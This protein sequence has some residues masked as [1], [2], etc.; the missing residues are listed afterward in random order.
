MSINVFKMTCASTGKSY[1]GMTSKDMMTEATNIFHLAERGGY[2][3]IAD[4]MVYDICLYGRDDFKVELIEACESAGEAKS[5]RADH[6]MKLKCRDAKG[7]NARRARGV[8]LN[9]IEIKLTPELKKLA[10]LGNSMDQVR[11]VGIIFNKSPGY[12]RMYQTRYER[13]YDMFA[14]IAPSITLEEAKTMFGCDELDLNNLAWYLSESRKETVPVTEL[15][16][17]E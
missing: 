11:A 15:L 5:V 4:H 16:K 6:I 10:E 2:N 8:D 14:N 17:S 12:I 9:A 7:Y 13:F 3:R 1:V